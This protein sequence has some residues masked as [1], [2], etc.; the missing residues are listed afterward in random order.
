MKHSLTLIL[1]LITG[2]SFSQTLKKYPVG[3]S[4]CSY[5]SY[6]EASFKTSVSQDSSTIYNGEC[7]TGEFAYGV[8]C[9]KLLN[10]ITE[11]KPAEDMLIAYLDY[12]K[13]SFGINKA[14]GYGKGHRLANDENT[15]GVLD[16]WQ[17]QENN[18][19]K[20]KGWTNGKYIAVLYSYSL[21]QLPEPK[22]NIFLDGFRFPATK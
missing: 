19:W 3:Q 16:Y 12:L 22:I 8:I 10:P 13:Q 4:G 1:I 11:N 5:Y 2:K 14:S 6:C 20:V 15:R 9:V 21:K 17:D 7:I 18:N